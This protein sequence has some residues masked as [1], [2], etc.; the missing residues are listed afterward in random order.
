VPGEQLWVTNIVT[1]AR[2]TESISLSGHGC[3]DA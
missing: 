3:S 2:T 1:I